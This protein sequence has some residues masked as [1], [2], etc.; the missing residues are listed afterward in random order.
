MGRFLLAW[1]LGGNYGHLAR[2]APVIRELGARGHDLAC[3]V[4]DL[5][6]TASSSRD[7][8]AV[9][10]LQAPRCTEPGLCGPPVSFCDIL[11][12]CGF[13]SPDRLRGV[14][15]GWHG[16]FEVFRPDAVV[17]EYAPSAVFA[18]GLAGI[19]CLRMD[20]GFAVPPDVAPW[21]CFRPW[22]KVS[23]H[24]LLAGENRMLATVNEL[25]ADYGRRG[26]EQLFQAVRADVTLLT[27]VPELDHYPVRRG[28][29]YIGPL[30]GVPAGR[31]VAW[32]EGHGSGIFCYLRPFRE[33]DMLLRVLKES[34]NRS[35]VVVPGCGRELYDRY[36]GDRLHI[37]GEPVMLPELL[38]GADLVVSHGGHTLASEAIL[39][40][41]PVLALPTQVEQMMLAQALARQGIGK[42][43]ARNRLAARFADTLHGM[44]SDMSI[45]RRTRELARKYAAYD[46]GE[47]L[48]RLVNTIE[49][50]PEVA[51]RPN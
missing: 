28:G 23:R 13:G 27:T 40:G 48:R 1:E 7:C 46:G 30:P 12:E 25:R 24:Q 10:V 34:G 41:V 5:A 44:V 14:V 8:S 3:A 37:F 16:L 20:T 43:I 22:L 17:A 29:H 15:R 45:K 31:S 26:H 39:A 33:L 2:L 32:P 38:G 35:I 49:R 19:P 47:T 9:V 36:H 6:L 4:P 50:L 51:E 18:A 42:G 11:K 21:P